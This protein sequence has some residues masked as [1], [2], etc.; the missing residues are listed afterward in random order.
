MSVM[1]RLP[2]TILQAAPWV[3]MVPWWFGWLTGREV[4]VL[5]LSS[6]FGFCMTMWYTWPGRLDQYDAGATP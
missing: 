4:C 3:A 2:I 1:R 6:V 5:S